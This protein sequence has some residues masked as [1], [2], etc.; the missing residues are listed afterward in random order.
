MTFKLVKLLCN[1]HNSYLAQCLVQ[2]RTTSYSQ[3]NT[4]KQLPVYSTRPRLT[5]RK[6]ASE[7]FN[8]RRHYYRVRKRR[9]ELAQRKSSLRM[10]KYENAPSL[11]ELRLLRLSHCCGVQIQRDI[12]FFVYL[13]TLVSANSGVSND[14]CIIKEC[15]GHVRFS[16]FIIPTFHRQS[17]DPVSW[18]SVN[19]PVPSVQRDIA[20]MQ[21]TPL[22][23]QRSLMTG[24]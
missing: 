23:A 8:H 4:E 3:H 2:N 24:N 18:Q 12:H 20:K 21:F 22:E 9:D 14:I 10:Q 17:G 16:Y 19:E 15:R 5:D 1:L 13:G 6:A 11:R 7:I